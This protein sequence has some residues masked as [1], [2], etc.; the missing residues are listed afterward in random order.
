MNFTDIVIGKSCGC[1][2]SRTYGTQK[3]KQRS[4]QDPISLPVWISKKRN[5]ERI[6]ERRSV[7]ERRNERWNIRKMELKKIKER[8]AEGE[9]ETRNGI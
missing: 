3:Q 7:G 9:G 8:I 5:E 6:K 1:C 4:A 2:P